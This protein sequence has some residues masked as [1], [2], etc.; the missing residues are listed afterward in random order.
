MA[1]IKIRTGPA[2]TSLVERLAGD[3]IHARFYYHLLLNLAGE[4]E[5][6]PRI[7]NRSTGSG[8]SP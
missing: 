4:F 1:P 8:A 7:Y 6:D 3:I 2:M 5:R